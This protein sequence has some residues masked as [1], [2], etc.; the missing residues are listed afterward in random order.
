M[1]VALNVF[2]SPTP[3]TY[4]TTPVSPILATGSLMKGGV[5]HMTHLF[6]TVASMPDYF[7]A[8]GYR[9]PTDALD[10]PFN[11]AHDCKGSTYFEFLARPGNERL[12]ETFNETM[13]LQKSSEDVEFMKSY[14]AAE[15]LNITDPERVLFVDVGGSMGHQVRKFGEKYPELKGKLVLED[16]PQVVDKAVDVPSSIIKVGHDFFTPQPDVVKGAKAYYVRMVLHDWPEKQAV[17]ILSNIVDVMASDS[18]ILIH[19]SILPETGVG[20]LEAKLDWHMM[21]LGASE[22]TEKQWSALADSVGLKVN[23]IWWE[24]QGLGRRGLIELGKK[25]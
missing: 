2:T 22:R 5:V 19:E 6:R 12:S 17:K 10:A 13:E 7:A 21:N 1:L 16:L 4:A 20:H 3:T 23:G 9:N 15:R 14:P 18:V 24:E 25:A 8:N 11:F